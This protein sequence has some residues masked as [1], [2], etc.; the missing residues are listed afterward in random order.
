MT[1]N[2]SHRVRSLLGRIDS[3]TLWAF[4]PQPAL[5]RRTSAQHDA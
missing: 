4:N 2:N 1:A 3:W 5:V